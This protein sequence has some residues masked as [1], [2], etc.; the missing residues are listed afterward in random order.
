MKMSLTRLNQD[1][2]LA[3]NYSN[4][5]IETGGPAFIPSC[6]AISLQVGFGPPVSS[7]LIS[8]P[9]SLLYMLSMGPLPGGLDSLLNMD[10]LCLPYI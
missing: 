2:P 7:P 6:L 1:Y 10:K 3:S 4:S 5:E 9:L 8:L